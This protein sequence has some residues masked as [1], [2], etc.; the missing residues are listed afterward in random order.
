ML[1][2]LLLE[3]IRVRKDMFIDDSIFLKEFGVFFIFVI[4]W[5][6]LVFRD[7]EVKNIVILILVFVML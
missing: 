4:F 3:D 2:L 5:K 7:F 6:V 1:I